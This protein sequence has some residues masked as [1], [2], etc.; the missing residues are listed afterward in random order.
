MSSF[1]VVSTFI[2]SQ[3]TLDGQNLDILVND[4]SS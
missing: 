3:E 2:K 4:Q 1:T